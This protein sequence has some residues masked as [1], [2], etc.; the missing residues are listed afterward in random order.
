MSGDARSG[1]CENS[2]LGGRMGHHSK[3]AAVFRRAFDIVSAAAGLILLSPILAAISVAIKLSD[4]GPVFYSQNRVGRNF[5]SFKLIKFRTMVVGADRGQPITSSKD[6]RVTR[7]GHFLRSYKLDEL[8]QL[9]NILGGDMQLVGPRPELARYV[10]IFRTEYQI[11]LQHRPG[12][13]DPAS[14]AFRDEQSLLGSTNI[15]QKY[16]S[17]ILPQK[18]HVS[19][20]YAA[21]RTFLSD[22]GV[23]LRTLF[24]GTNS[25]PSVTEKI[26]QG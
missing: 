3:L 1:T 26:E 7:V 16:I 10:V 17:E 24:P 19:L 12:I 18:L 20:E 2:D 15:E 14:I 4:G 25:K 8:P 6:E 22:I 11:L 21:R 5:Q 23:I 13:T 9:V